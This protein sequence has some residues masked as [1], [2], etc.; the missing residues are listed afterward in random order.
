ML[1]EFGAPMDDGRD[2]NEADSD[3]DF[4]RH[5]QA[6]TD[7]AREHGMGSVYWPALGGKHT[8]RPDYDWYSLFALEGSGT[9]LSLTLRN[10]SMVDRLHHA[11]GLGG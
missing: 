2:Y 5:I 4:V 9:D 3:D 8:Q 10:E 11:W 6:G 1:D 7:T